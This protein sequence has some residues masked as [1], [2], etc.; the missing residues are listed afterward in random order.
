MTKKSTGGKKSSGIIRRT[1]RTFKNKEL[2]ISSKT[3][4]S[5][6]T[7]LG[8]DYTQMIASLQQMHSNISELFDY[9]SVRTRA[10]NKLKKSDRLLLLAIIGEIYVNDTRYSEDGLY[11]EYYNHIKYIWKELQTITLTLGRIKEKDKTQQVLLTS[12]RKALNCV[13]N[14]LGFIRDFVNSKK[15]LLFFSSN[16]IPFPQFSID[17]FEN[18]LV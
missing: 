2:Y 5:A 9:I 13:L 10:V 12:A 4:T 18:Q 17:S 16:N 7:K 6:L 11:I 3:R 8:K 15:T 14:A 1:P